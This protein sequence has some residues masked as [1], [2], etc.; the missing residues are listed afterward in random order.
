MFGENNTIQYV[1]NS[2][3]NSNILSKFKKN[4]ASQNGEDG[5]IEQIFNIITPQN[6]WCVEFGAADG[7]W[8]SNTY[9]LDV[10]YNWKR[11]LIEGDINRYNKLYES[12]CNCDKN[13]IINSM[14]GFEKNNLDSIL[15]TTEIPIN[16]DF[17]SIDIDG[18]DYYIWES[19]LIYK[20]ILISIEF[21]P[22]VPNDITFIQVK[23][24]QISQGSSLLALILLGK[25]KEYELI[26]TTSCNAFFLLKEYYDEFNIP[27]NNIH[28]MRYDSGYRIWEGFDGTVFTSNFNQLIWKNRKVDFEDL[29]VL[30]KKERGIKGGAK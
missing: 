23:D 2:N 3:E 7:K 8:L 27:N 10:N 9:N 11:I 24:M 15:S 28:N 6:K 22:I 16:F 13:I 20:P 19:L 14:V 4:I 17:L 5:I 26:A 12:D 30:S 25:Q 18:C 21:N 29:Q 1:Q